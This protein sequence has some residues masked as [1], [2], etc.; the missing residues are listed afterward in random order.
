M[1]PEKLGRY[2]IL[3]ELGKGAMGVVYLA[4]DP[5]I[6]RQV[7]LKTFRL[8]SNAEDE[9]VEQFRIRFLRE[10]QSA[11]ILNHPNIVTIHDVVDE[12]DTSVC[13]IAMEYVKGTDLKQLM[14]R[15]K[16]LALPFVIETVAQIADGLDYAHSKGVVHR[17]VKPANVIITAA[18]EAKI[19]DFGIARLDTSNLTME[20]Q[21]L[22][23]PNYMAP[24][25]VRGR[26]VDHRADLF[27][28]GV[29]L[30]E[31]VTGKKP[32]AGDNLTVV[33]HRIVNEAFTPPDEFVPGVPP[34]LLTV[35]DRALRKKPEERYQRGS[36]MAQDLRALL[37]PKPEEKPSEAAKAE[38]TSFLDTA[39]AAPPAAPA[40][41][42]PP[43][44]A[45]AHPAAAPPPPPARAPS[46][47]MERPPWSRA[48]IF[49]AAAAMLALVLGF[50]G[51]FAAGVSPERLFVRK[52][53]SFERSADPAFEQM[54]AYLPHLKAGQR[55][56]SAGEPALALEAFDRALREV[57][58][59]RD[60]RR[61]RDRAEREVLALEGL[62]QEQ[63]YV[64]RRMLSAQAAFDRRDYQ[65]T[66]GLTREVLA[67]DPENE[68]AEELQ[69]RAEEG[70][71]RRRTTLARLSG[72]PRGRP[73]SE[74]ET[75]AE[76]PGEPAPAEPQTP[77]DAKGQLAIVFFT[78]VSEGTLTI[79]GGSEQILKEEFRFVERVNVFKTRKTA[80]RI[81]AT[82]ELPSGR[83]SLKI[84]VYRR[85]VG[86][87]FTELEGNLPGGA[88]RKL[89]IE[90]SKEGRLT[91]RLE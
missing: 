13:F 86:T 75:A 53:Q 60:I 21:L 12:G 76:P 4:R 35:L 28:L 61:L 49:A 52:P 33:S 48:A 55:H 63:A 69:T 37:A 85:G 47:F 66:L 50:V 38:S 20:G 83:L 19:T 71:E 56:L 72:S 40:V 15:Q 70:L 45:A 8:A 36:E 57:P 74:P 5:V 34:G 73:R 80:G 39:D 41:A 29:V 82:R 43:A 78:E 46:P 10:A 81:T 91:A 16:R 51:A 7:A 90:V 68:E 27:S 64:A 59:N 22:G 62:D 79:Y 67:V 9:E 3:G 31:L 44:P 25:Q 89:D 65:E 1:T 58:Q 32:F 88:T 84:Y 30:Y 23:T 42:P 17:D 6:G 87:E 2:E 54:L 11:G 77:A 24:E 18:K 26:D 14:K